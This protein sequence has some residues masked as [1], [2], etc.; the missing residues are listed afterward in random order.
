MW[1][2]VCNNP[3]FVSTGLILFLN[4]RDL[5]QQKLEAGRSIKAI[6]PDYA[7]LCECASVCI[8]VNVLCCVVRLCRDKRAAALSAVHQRRVLQQ[9]HCR[10]KRHVCLFPSL[11]FPSPTSAYLLFL[12]FCLLLDCLVS[13]FVHMT[14]AT[15][16]NLIRQVFND[17]KSV[18]I[19]LNLSHAGI[20]V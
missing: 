10:R 15:D 17:C 19:R 20:D 1:D 2:E 6:F 8:C 11:P 7:G 14:T 4:K 3:A 9:V 16:T 5:F 12:C 18:I 13:S